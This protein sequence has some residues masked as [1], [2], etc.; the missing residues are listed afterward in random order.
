[1]TL[2]F[3]NPTIL[4]GIISRKFTSNKNN[5]ILKTMELKASYLQHLVCAALSSRSQVFPKENSFASAAGYF[6]CWSNA[7][8]IAARNTLRWSISWST[9]CTSAACVW[10]NLNHVMSQDSIRARLTT[11]TWCRRL[12]N[13]WVVLDNKGGSRRE[14]KKK[15]KGE[16][17]KRGN[18]LNKLLPLLWSSNRGRRTAL[19]SALNKHC[20]PTTTYEA[21]LD[22]KG[23]QIGR[24]RGVK[25]CWEWGGDPSDCCLHKYRG[26]SRGPPKSRR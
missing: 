15:G 24:E 12:P 22:V 18:T 11:P 16:K 9:Q 26:K 23:M 14:K 13:T 2:K 17:K 5:L 20:G 8:Q 4:E 7:S 25:R 3:Q 21:A 6:Y 1:M 10:S 19:P